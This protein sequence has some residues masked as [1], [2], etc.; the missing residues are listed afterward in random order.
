MGSGIAHVA[1]AAG[2]R[3]LLHDAMPG[4]ATAAKRAVS[5]RLARRVA[6][7]KMNGE[8][9]AALVDRIRVVDDVAGF[10][11][12]GLVVEAVVEDLG[13]KRLLFGRFEEVVASTVV[14][15]SNTSSLSITDIAAGLLHPGRVVGM[16]FFN[17]AP[18]LP[19]VEVASGD[20]T[21][22]EAA[23][24]AAATAAA[25]GK[26]PVRCAS[27]PGFI[28]NRC[29]RPF[30]GEAWM[31]VE[32]GVDPELVDEVMRGSGA[33]PMGPFELMDLIGHDVSLAVSRSVHAAFSGDVRFAPFPGQI[34]LVEEGRLGRKSGRGVYRW[35][36]EEVRTPD[37]VTPGP[38]PSLITVRGEVGPLAALAAAAVG[39]G[40]AV[41][42]Q[43]GPGVID[44]D[45]VTLAVTDGRTITERGGVD[46]LID[47]AFDYSGC[48]LL[49]VAGL[50]AAVRKV[51]GLAAAIGKETIAVAD[52][53]G[54]VVMRTVC[55]LVAFAADAVE[56]GVASADA[57]D[58]AMKLG[59]NYPVGP[60]QWGRS[61]GFDRVVAVL[62]RLDDAV[63]GGRYT[64]G[65]ML[66]RLGVGGG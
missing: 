16:H 23:G 17:P 62:D 65:P 44:I 22:E 30:Y 33:F 18:V 28:V 37:R 63:P 59:V 2:H 8:D 40:V 56:D 53:P 26:T 3:V 43:A 21:T 13:V 24:T 52:V 5:D 31:L 7:G 14:L 15:A 32:A 6:A 45:G 47:L 54:L 49:A 50:P 35:D 29:A 38:A 64:A 4:A 60:L 39:G 10:A 36:P 19:L 9:A 42:Q 12:V 46:A 11:D 20:A 25:W 1:A 57:V 55:T 51:A 48:R 34:S 61:I 41:V 66:R 27:T 58:T